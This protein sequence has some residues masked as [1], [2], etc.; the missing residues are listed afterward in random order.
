DEYVAEYKDAEM[1]FRPFIEADN[2][3]VSDES[4]LWFHRNRNEVFWNEVMKANDLLDEGIPNPLK[5]RT[6]GA[7]VQGSGLKP[8]ND[9]VL[10]TA[11]PLKKFTIKT[12]VLVKQTD[13]E[14]GY[15]NALSGLAAALEQKPGKEMLA[16]HKKCWSDFWNRSYV[17][18]GSENKALNDTLH[19]LNRG[20]ILQ[21]YVNAIGGRGELPVK[22]N[23]A[24][25]VLDTYHN[26][27]GNV[28]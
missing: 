19:A 25:L 7:L 16:L 9:T 6:S 8:L 15:V 5:N 17:F 10:Y 27:I 13:T 11:A 20:Y 1:P 24:T 28:S 18:F 3:R 21:R 26:N 2:A 23:G 4:I 14:D 22:F 12:T